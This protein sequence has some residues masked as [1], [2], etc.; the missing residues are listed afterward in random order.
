MKELSAF[1]E[2]AFWESENESKGDGGEE[3]EPNERQEFRDL[4]ISLI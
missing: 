4:E 3:D 2:K 1:S